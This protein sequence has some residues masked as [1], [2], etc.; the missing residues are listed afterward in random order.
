MKTIKPT[1]TTR[2]TLN[3]HWRYTRRYLPEFLVGTIGAVLAVITQSMI[4]PLIVAR[5]FSKLQT[6]YIRHQALHFSTFIPYLWWF[7]AA[8][9]MGVVFWRVQAY[10]VWQYEVKI[11]RDI[12]NDVF[13]HLQVQS[14][15]F[16]ADRF[17]GALVSQTNKFNAAYE[18]LMDSFIWNI[19]P[20]LTTVVV[21]IGVLAFIAWAY[22]LALLLVV[23]VYL[24]LM[25][26]R[27]SKQLPFNARVAELESHQTAALADAITNVSTIRAFAGEKYETKRFANV[28]GNLFKANNILS[29]EIM[30]SEALSHVQTNGFQVIALLGGLLSITTYHFSASLLYLLISYTQ[31]ITSQILQ[32]SRLVRDLN[33]SLGDSVE[34]TQILG[35][36]PDVLD[37]PQPEEAL[38]SR[39]EVAFR[40]V[41]FAYPENMEQPLFKDLNLKVKPGEKVGLV[42]PSGGGKTTITQLLLRFMD[43]QDGA[44]T[45]DGQNIADV[46]QSDLRSRIAYVSQEPILFHRTLAENIGYGGLGAEQSVIEGV[47]KMANAHEFISQ[48]PKGY[49]T[50]VGER[51]VKLSGGQRQRVAI[52]RAMLKNAPILVLDEATSA[53]DSESEVLIQDALWKLMEGRTAIVIAHRLSTI[54][55]MDRIIVLDEGQVVEQGSHKELL[56]NKDGTYARLWAHQSGGFIND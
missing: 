47:A 4:P 41:A 27:M 16:H 17:G 11:R 12:A 8:M 33:R 39:G 35:I 25:W 24:A 37:P 10:Y 15:R 1:S 44:I 36:T 7:A 49:G 19:V 34:M 42:G 38:M 31:N 6:A 46:R 9:F 52:A 51:G 21:A 28:S 56:S 53:L 3:I 18:R 43:V 30:K 32:F 23:L 45:I 13:N 22:A 26:R 48:L 29:V 40:D 55:R 14:Q 2:K 54:Q 50:L 20:S 5:V